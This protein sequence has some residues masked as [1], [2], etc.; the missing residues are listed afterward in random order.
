MGAHRAA[1]QQLQPAVSAAFSTSNPVMPP[2]FHSPAMPASPIDLSR[3][4]PVDPQSMQLQQLMWLQAQQQ[5]AAAGAS[6]ML[7]FAGLPP[8]ASHA[9]PDWY[10]ALASQLAPAARLHPGVGGPLLHGPA[11]A[12]D[13]PFPLRWAWY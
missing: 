3:M 7:P 9:A 11:D 12:E 5:M 1:L 4:P 6:G 13:M 10:H 8:P 2:F